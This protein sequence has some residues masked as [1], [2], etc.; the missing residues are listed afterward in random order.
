[1]FPVCLSWLNKFSDG[2]LWKLLQ[3]ARAHVCTQVSF[4][5][6]EMLLC[7]T[8]GRNFVFRVHIHLP[9]ACY[10]TLLLMWHYPISWEMAHVSWCLFIAWSHSFRQLEKLNVQFSLSPWCLA[11]Q[12]LQ[13]FQFLQL[14]A[15]ALHALWEHCPLAVTTV[16]V[17]CLCILAAVMEKMAN[18]KGSAGH[19]GREPPFDTAVHL[20]IGMYTLHQ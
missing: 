15:V 16:T 13:F 5:C 7:C 1:M 8:N 20:G 14:Q 6:V 4:W 3:N 18:A 19:A 10:H 11:V 17:L 12:K 2:A 9:V